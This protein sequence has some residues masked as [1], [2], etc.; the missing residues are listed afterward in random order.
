MA[1]QEI[2]IFSRF[3]ELNQSVAEADNHLVVVITHSAV[4]CWACPFISTRRDCRLSGE[5]EAGAMKCWLSPESGNSGGQNS[6]PL[7]CLAFPCSAQPHNCHAPPS[8]PAP[9]SCGKQ[10]VFY[11]RPIWRT[12]R[13]Y[14]SAKCL[15]SVPKQK[16][17]SEESFCKVSPILC[18][19]IE[20]QS[21]GVFLQCGSHTLYHKVSNEIQ[22]LSQSNLTS[23]IS[24]MLF[25]FKLHNFSNT[26]VFTRNVLMK[27]R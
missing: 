9:T 11:Y 7:S 19:N 6:A 2:K 20:N 14:L 24:K 18:T 3:C 22:L 5:E 13:R 12:R 27:R 1:K 8:P 23:E 16:T 15:S 21:R 25:S 10:Q 17:S 26:H 4:V